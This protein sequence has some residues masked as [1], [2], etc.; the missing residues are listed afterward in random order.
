MK[1]QIDEMKISTTFPSAHQIFA[2]IFTII[3]QKHCLIGALTLLAT[4]TRQF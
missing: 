4:S 3:L 1:C 2:I